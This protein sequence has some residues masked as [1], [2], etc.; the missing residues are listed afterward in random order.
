MSHAAA[1]RWQRLHELFSELADAPA[2]DRARRLA[3]VQAADPALAAELQALLAADANPISANALDHRLG[4]AVASAA[5]TLAETDDHPAF[6]G[7][8][9]IVGTL[10]SGGMGTVYLAEQESPRRT[11][12]LK[13]IR[14]LG[15]ASAV[16]RFHREAELHG[17]LQHPGIALV[18]EAGVATERDSDGAERGPPRPFFAMEYVKGEPLVA[19]VQRH[20]LPTNERVELVARICDAIEHAHS[21][22]VIHRDLKSANVLVDETGAPKVLDFGIAR[23]VDRDQATTLQTG[24]GEVIGTLPYMSPEQV[25]GDPRAVGV[26][27]DVYALGVLLFEVLTG[28][29]PLDLTG[30]TI[31]EAVRMVVDDEPTRLS[32]LDRTLRGDLDTIVSRCLEKDPARRYA[33]AGALAE[34]LRRHLEHRPIEAR[35]ASTAYQLSK[36]A[37]RN[38][39]LVAGVCTAF[40]ALLAATVISVIMTVQARQAGEDLRVQLEAARRES[41][42]SVQSFEFLRGLL[43]AADPANSQGKDLTVRELVVRAADAL[44][45]EEEGA[46]PEVR[47]MLARLIGYT[48][49]R[50]GDLERAETTLKR[51]AELLKRA[52][53]NAVSPEKFLVETLVNLGD[54]L[55]ERGKLDE[56]AAVLEE[57]LAVRRIT[58]LA[59]LA[60]AGREVGPEDELVDP[61]LAAGLN[62]LSL[63]HQTRGDFAGA[64]RT[65]R[66]AYEMERALVEHGYNRRTNMATALVNMASAQLLQG[67][68]V[69]AEPALR[70]AVATHETLSGPDAPITQTVRNNLSSCLRSNGRYAES[71]AII[72]TVIE[73]R[74]R[75]LPP[76]HY[77]I[78]KGES[79]LGQTLLLSGRPLEA[80]EW[81]DRALRSSIQNQGDRHQDVGRV[82]ALRAVALAQVGRADEALSEA[83]AAVAVL[84]ATAGPQ[85]IRTAE[86]L[87]A[88]AQV[89]RLAGRAGPS[90]TTATR[91]R[92]AAA[93]TQGPRHP[94]ALQARRELA[95]ADLALGEVAAGEAE[96]AA[97]LAEG[98]AA[99]GESFTRHPST[100]LLQLARA[101]ALARLPGRSPDAAALARTAA[102]TLALPGGP[103]PWRARYAQLLATALEGAPPSA[104]EV[105]ALAQAIAQ[106]AGAGMPE[107]PAM[108]ARLA[109]AQAS[110]PGLVIVAPA[111]L[112]PALEAFIAFKSARLPTEFIELEAALGAHPGADDAERLKRALHDAWKNRH[113]RY[114]LL[115][116]DVDCLPVRYMALDRCTP[117][118]FNYAFYP[119]DLYYADLVDAHGEFE[120]WNGRSDG[121]HAG[122]LGEVRGECNKGDPI[123][124]DGVH[125]L[126]ELA[127]GR[128]PASD[129]ERV[130]RIAAKGI[131][132]ELRLEGD[133]HPAA[134]VAGLVAV[135]GWVDARPHMDALATKLPAGWT[136]ERRYDDS[137]ELAPATEAEVIG[138]LNSGAGLVLHAGHGND[139]CWERCLPMSALPSLQN[140]DRLPVMVS[141]GCSTANFAPLPPYTAY[142]DA[143]GREHAGTNHGEVFVEPPPPPACYQR[144]PLNTGGLGEALLGARDSGAVAYIGCCTGSQPCGLTLLEGFAIAL[145]GS[146]KPR[147]GEC[148]NDA[149]R[150]YHAAQ[151]LEALVPDDGWYPPSI[152]FQGMKFVVFGDPSL[153]LAPTQRS[154]SAQH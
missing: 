69:E 89:Q 119:S 62:N 13:V 19:F 48:L 17:R 14:A 46:S 12:A 58:L 55:R 97:L 8:Y 126:P 114:A 64:E 7:D 121:F 115:V 51:S 118:A 20:G 72:R 153:P 141:A 128:W 41:A 3:E 95:L 143:Q 144:G 11:V 78:G 63:V 152:F 86:G 68:T 39:G 87:V 129:P 37:R 130:A 82:R 150:H 109:G 29:R 151:R 116:G 99:E 98:A 38:R 2:A 101:E 124:F 35:P 26:R 65:A 88:A 136:I 5:A 43:T 107:L 52:D 91:A 147:L 18:H 134:R 112:R 110:S 83:E 103:H 132:H 74:Q 23:A 146:A 84:E 42:R 104:A 105:D 22:G 93:A 102:A 120:D 27:S 111:R 45:K 133:A 56:A 100:A 138:L 131:A 117:V 28:R 33:S 40:V 66:L 81:F 75:T 85:H 149:I 113:A 31:P 30:R 90:R 24:V 49:A 123:N 36:F 108:R 15:G 77:E 32:T 61:S 139:D 79:N 57:S 127:V 80:I 4:R 34:D 106:V 145:G 76:G 94:V 142:T 6:I 1:D 10:G 70:E 125:Y 25:S 67:R 140:A 9:R 50:L 59:Q 122:Y 92:A 148:W 96:L 135:A 73:A 16:R 60:Q 54:V 53:P 154:A 71:E 44:Q 47:G 21:R 137:P